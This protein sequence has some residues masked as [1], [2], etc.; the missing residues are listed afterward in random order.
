MLILI[1]LAC[2]P[3]TADIELPTTIEE[4]DQQD[5]TQ[6]DDPDIGIDTGFPEL[7]DSTLEIGFTTAWSAAVWFPA[8]PG[9]TEVNLGAWTFRSTNEEEITVSNVVLSGYVDGDEDE[10]MSST[11]EGGVY[12]PDYLANCKL[13]EVVSRDVVMGPMDPATDGTLSFPDDFIV[14]GEFSTALNLVCDITEQA[15]E[16]DY[17][18]FAFDLTTIDA[19]ESSADEMVLTTV[20][21]APEP[22][23]AAYVDNT[24]EC[25]FRVEAWE[26][27]DNPSTDGVTDNVVTMANVLDISLNSDTPSGVTEPGEIE[28]LRLNFAARD[29][30]CADMTVTGFTMYVS[31]TDNAD[32]DWFD[33]MD[34]VWARNLSTGEDLG[35]GYVG[36]CWKD[37]CPQSTAGMY[38]D[39]DFAGL[40]I[41]AGSTYTVA[42]Y[43][44]TTGASQDWDDSLQVSL[45]PSQLEATDGEETRV[46]RFDTIAGGTIQF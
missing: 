7:F 31:A 40:T 43:M 13:V 46:L 10:V 32:T 34:T 4:S 39:E 24:G 27:D 41:P 12:L 16:F 33:A 21:G 29:P 23:L 35:D 37:G 5:D 26:T 3:D 6:A 18:A 38:M 30:D 20:N 28:V 9:Q 42:F 25:E 45:A 36:V 15:S 8:E 14:G 1:A 44:D 22:T 2:A 17:A 11:Q 19:V